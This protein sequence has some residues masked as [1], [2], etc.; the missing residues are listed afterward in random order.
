MNM[1]DKLK[2]CFGKRRFRTSR[3]VDEFLGH[4][5]EN[6]RIVHEHTA[7]YSIRVVLFGRTY[8]IAIDKDD[9]ANSMRL[10]YMV[11]REENRHERVTECVWASML[12]SRKVS[13]CFWE[14]LH[15]TCQERFMSPEEYYEASI[16]RHLSTPGDMGSSENI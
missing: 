10:C 9:A 1:K 13:F 7:S 14:W 6:G 16:L 8:D 2:I 5:M 11:L 3:W 15:K 4:V 12:P